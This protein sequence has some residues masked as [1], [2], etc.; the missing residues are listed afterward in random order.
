VTLD[1]SFLLRKDNE[2]TTIAVEEVEDGLH[3]NEVAAM[4][5]TA[6]GQMEE[7][8]VYRGLVNGK[9]LKADVVGYEGDRVLV[10][11]PRETTSG[12]WRVWMSKD[13]VAA[14]DAAA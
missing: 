13:S 4:I 11:L 8:F 1:L 12:S 9:R 6:D 10:E 5:R 14:W 2:M 7:V 3:P